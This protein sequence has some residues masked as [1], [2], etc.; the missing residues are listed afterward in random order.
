MK[1]AISLS[2]WVC[3]VVKTRQR[4]YFRKAMKNISC[5]RNILLFGSDSSIYNR[6]VN[7]ST[8]LFLKTLLFPT[9]CHK[10]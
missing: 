8:G 1:N 10:N 7:F 5:F 3:P 9:G 2:Y 6:G 4:D